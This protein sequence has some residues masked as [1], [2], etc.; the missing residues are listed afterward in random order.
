MDIKKKINE[1]NTEA[2]KLAFSEFAKSKKLLE[3]IVGLSKKNKYI[4]GESNAYHNLGIAHYFHNDYDK[5]YTYY[6]QAYELIKDS[7]YYERQ[8]AALHNMAVIN[9]YRSAFQSAVIQ[10]Q[11]A[12]KLRR[13]AKDEHFIALSLNFL[14]R[15]YDA[16]ND[17]E[18][19]LICFMEEY[20]IIKRKNDPA[21]LIN[22][23]SC[24]GHIYYSQ[25]NYRKALEY[26]IEAIKIGE[27]SKNENKTADTIRSAGSCYTNLEDYEKS[28]EMLNKSL[29]LAKK[30]KN[31]RV[32]SACYNDLGIF[33]WKQNNI[34]K[35]LH[36]HRQ[37][38][39]LSR[40]LNA[41][42]ETVMSLMN[43]GQMQIE[44][45][46]FSEA[47]ISLEEGTGLAKKYND[48]YRLS[49]MY[50]K[51]GQLYAEQDKFKEAY[52]FQ[53]KYMEITE[54]IS[55]NEK[56]ELIEKLKVEFDLERKEREAELHKLKNVTLVETNKKL[57]ESEK[58]LLEL[59]QNLEQ[60]VLEELKKRQQQ[61]QQLIQK[62]KLES[63][64]KLAAGIAHE[65]NQPLGGISMGLENI[66]FAHT[67]G[68]LT[69]K[70]LDEKL[71]HIDG[72]FERIKQIIEHIRI[73][74]RD[75]K[76]VLFEN[77][78]INTTVNDALSLLQTQFTNHN[79]QINLNLDENIPKISGNKF[80]LEQV[81]LNL[82]TNAKDAVDEKK[83]STDTSYKKRIT[84][85][86]CADDKNI[87]LEIEDNGNGISSDNLKSIFDPFFTT[88]DPAKGT[89]L[90][91][92]IIYGIIKEMN[93]EIEAESKVGEFTKM[94][95]KLRK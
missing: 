19:A 35:S 86:T 89:G 50:E 71:K 21:E 94:R 48:Q 67:E 29:K 37:A 18:K 70:Y 13:T 65:I 44:L 76:S 8:A 15:C 28:L 45:K 34:T 46:M 36:Y 33:Y 27:E 88:K 49:G 31:E 73:F 11:K 14:G 51:M 54:I 87:F 58:D 26:F 20:K 39:A 1:M 75:Q 52:E 72:Y 55:K 80:K 32:E 2:N 41:V 93:G 9:F 10:N 90:G 22:S 53:K 63:I 77:V 83:R 38:L 64:G 6:G 5:A 91:L 59:N 17:L 92:S 60:R 4:V 25:K 57:T 43:V 30:L 3:E 62:S 42:R 82:M 79:V 47:E 24:I 16:A 84:I 40:K 68:R 7:K 56:T 95:V 69:E 66:Y 74:S 78:D 81:V 61:Q 23:L 85:R 12:L